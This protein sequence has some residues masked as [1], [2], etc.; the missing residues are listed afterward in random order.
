MTQTPTQSSRFDFDTP[1]ERR[2]TRSMKWGRYPDDVIPM[3]V[4]DMDFHVA[5]PITDA[6]RKAVDHGVFGYMMP[7]PDLAPT[8]VE[9]MERLYNWTIEPQDIIYTPGVIV[10]INM[11]AQA[12]AQD[13]TILVQPP[14][15]HPFHAIP[16][17]S[18]CGKQEAP[19][20]YVETEDGF[21][22][23]IDFDVFEAAITPETRMILLSNPH[24]PIGRVWTRDELAQVA[25]IAERHDLIICSDEIHADLIL[26]GYE[27]VPTASISPEAAA[28]T[29]TYFAPSKTF[30]LPGLTFSFGIIQNPDL[31]ARV[32]EAA[33]GLTALTMGEHVMFPVNS[34]GFTAADAAYRE[35][36]AWLEAV[37]EYIEIN[38]DF[39]RA[40][41]SENMPA[42]KCGTLEGTYLQ[43]IDCRGANLPEAAGD[44]FLKE[45]KVA[46]NDGEMFGVGGSGFVRMNLA[47][48]RLILTEALNRMAA[49]LRAYQSA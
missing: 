25:E 10:G 39:T 42:L 15:Y 20:R 23:E 47:T 18:D 28:R 14:V 22:Y 5:P 49:A 37:L 41:I 46:L 38:R 16:K 31:R 30:N 24:N 7:P 45:A 33:K 34:L 13:G 3:W 36:G 32:L 9:R 12:V 2:H 26:S 17:W 6:L 29:V 44:W 27:H 19:L 40:Y 8:L 21:T 1:L 11:V 48:S 4:A 35:G 43:W